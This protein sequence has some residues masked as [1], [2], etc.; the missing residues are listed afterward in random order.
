M[1]TVVILLTLVSP[2]G[3]LFRPAQDFAHSAQADNGRVMKQISLTQLLT[4]TRGEAVGFGDRQ[5]GFDSIVT[6]SRKIRPGD[7]FWALAGEQHDGHHFL[8]DGF[9]RGAAAAVV[10]EDAI[11]PRDRRGH[12]DCPLI[13][14][15]DTLTALWDL[16]R[17]YRESREA[18]VVGVTGSFGKTTTRAMIHAALDARYTGTQSPRNFNNHV[19]VPLSILEIEDEH[20][21]AVLEFGASAIGEIRRLAEMA[22]PEI[23]VITGI[24]PAHLSGFGSEERILASK[25]ELL[26]ALPI[27]GIAFLSGDD[28]RLRQLAKRAERQVVLVGEGSH[29]HV[30]ATEIV[31]DQNRLSFRVGSDRFN[32]AV[33]GRHHLTAALCAVA[34]AREIGIDSATIAAGLRSFSAVPGRCQLEQIGRWTV[35]NDTY[36][37]NPASMQAACEVLREWKT[38]G[39]KLLVTGDMLELGERS[40]E[41][42]RQLGES[43]WGSGIDYLL[44]HGSQAK[45]VIQGAAEAGWDAYRLAECKSFETMLAVIRCWLEPGDV[46]LVKGSRGMR[47]ERVVDWLR[48]RAANEAH[49]AHGSLRAC[50]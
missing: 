30:R 45:H 15:R 11:A 40:D 44:V 42:H 29:N 5:S 36:N 22:A 19:G 4:A 34:V 16:A 39:R 47:M 35:I 37:A 13:V 23:G 10:R 9:R 31:V 12:H 25:S 1:L 6:D 14:V 38:T 26:E 49:S 50:A 3:V 32:L 46:I 18:F 27:G 43:V 7:L 21:F 2:V 33:A 41:Y 8:A 17:W 24:G 20:E 48:S 28:P